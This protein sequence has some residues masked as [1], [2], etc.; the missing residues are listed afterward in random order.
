MNH[1]DEQLRELQAQ[2]TRK[3]KLEASAAE[4]RTQRD[5]YR[6]RAQE[7]EQSF[8]QEQA[9]VDRLEGRSLSAFFYNVIGK[10]DEKLTQEKQEAY[11]A[12]VKYDAA[13]RELAGIEEDLHRC[14]AELESLQGCES[15]YEAVL[16]EKIQAVKKAGGD[17]AEQILKLEERT[18]YLESQKRELE[19]AVSAGRAALTTADQIAGSLDSAEGW[20]TWDLFG[21]GLISDLAKHSHLD[22]AQASVEF[23]QSQLRRFKTEL[24]D[25]TISAD[26]QVNIDG[27]LRVADYLFDGI[28]ADW[29]VLDQIHQS[30]AQIQDTRSQ[31]CNVLDYLHALM[32]R[33]A[34]EQADLRHE[35]EELVNCV[36]M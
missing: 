2:C 30:Q 12:R 33:T 9:D 16:K 4:L 5:T 23:L 25:V 36:P 27:F 19:E 15:R 31:I 11:A 35:L 1:Y 34:A 20:G 22:D 21:G 26:F 29:T 8:Q 28:F 13:A 18:A 3:K 6:L 32:D 7:L 17:V 24:S 14:E 10:M